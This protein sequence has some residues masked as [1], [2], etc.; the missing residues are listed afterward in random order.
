VLFYEEIR[1]KEY[2]KKKICNIPLFIES[3]CIFEAK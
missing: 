3:F 2:Y 1:K